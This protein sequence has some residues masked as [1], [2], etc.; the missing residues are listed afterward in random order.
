[1]FPKKNTTKRT[2]IN[3]TFDKNITF[4]SSHQ[5]NTDKRLGCCNIGK[6]PEWYCTACAQNMT[7]RYQTNALRHEYQVLHMNK[8]SV[9]IVLIR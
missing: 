6:K 8:Q 5:Q 4:I 9:L 3:T 7:I 2:V 1:M